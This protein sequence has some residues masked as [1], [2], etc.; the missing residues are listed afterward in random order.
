MVGVRE[1]VETASMDAILVVAEVFCV[2]R[3][4]DLVEVADA[5]RAETDARP[6]VTN[7]VLD[8]GF[9]DQQS[10]SCGV[11]YHAGAVPFRLPVGQAAQTAILPV[12]ADPMPAGPGQ[13]RQRI[14]LAGGRDLVIGSP[15]RADGVHRVAAAPSVIH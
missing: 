9:L 15:I 2:G 5:L 8:V 3:G 4:I 1:V 11:S 14:L 7:D 12:N 13:V 10:G 6:D